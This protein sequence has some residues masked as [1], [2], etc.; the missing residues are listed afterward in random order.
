M[1][2]LVIGQYG[3]V[4][5]DVH[6]LIDLCA[7]RLAR[8]HWQLAGA[9]SEQE[10]RSWWVGHCRR[11][12]GVAAVRAMARHRIRRVPYIGVPRAV[13]DERVRRGVAAGGT[14]PDDADLHAYYTFQVHVRTRAD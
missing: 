3:E 7:R 13:L 8:K 4:S 9:R 6:A 5:L 12:I 2:G 10:A 1:R 14:N 11:R